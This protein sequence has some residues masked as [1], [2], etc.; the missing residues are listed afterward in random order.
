MTKRNRPP[1]RMDT[2]FVDRHEEQLERIGQ[3]VAAL[4]LI[5]SVVLIA[6]G[7]LRECSVP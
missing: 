2:S 7:V 4:I 1:P 6:G 5:G 3:W